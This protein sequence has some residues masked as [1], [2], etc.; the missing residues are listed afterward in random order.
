MLD[1]E[2]FNND[3]YSYGLLTDGLISP[4]VFILWNTLAYLFTFK[5]GVM[6]PVYLWIIIWKDRT[7]FWMF[8][9]YLQCFKS[10]LSWSA[11]LQS[12]EYCIIYSILYHRFVKETPPHTMKQVIFVGCKIK[13]CSEKTVSSEKMIKLRYWM[14]LRNYSRTLTHSST[15]T[16]AT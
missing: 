7:G 8:L 14:E 6:L 5:D 9:G 1:W 16:K 13:T 15:A 10:P 4:S 2:Q 11:P 12:I 3:V